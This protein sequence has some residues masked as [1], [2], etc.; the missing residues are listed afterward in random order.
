MLLRFNRSRLIS[1]KQKLY[2]N[3]TK[4]KIIRG[5]FFHFAGTRWGILESKNLEKSASYYHETDQIG[6]L[7]C[8]LN[9]F[10]HFFRCENNANQDTRVT[11]CQNEYKN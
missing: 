9:I 11:I 7:R 8:Y 10:L 2:L 6:V 3:M 1:A 5:L 4:C